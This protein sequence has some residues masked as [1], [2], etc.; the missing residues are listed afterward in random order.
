M[1]NIDISII[2]PTCHR[3]T[4]LVEAM[5]SV[6]SQRDVVLELIVVDDS[7]EGSARDAATSLRDPRVRYFARSEPSNGRPAHARNDGAAGAQGRYLYFLDDDDIL[8]QGTLATLSA[9]LDAALRQV[10][11]SGGYAFGAMRGYCGTIKATSPR[12]DA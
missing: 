8:E 5:T 11:H 9:A 12:L 7:A 10:W 6:L 4:Q 1:D 3:E 2:I